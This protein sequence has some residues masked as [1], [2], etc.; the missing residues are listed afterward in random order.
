MF[1]H[2]IGE[3]LTNLDPTPP[4]DG[5]E[6]ILESGKYADYIESRLNYH[7]DNAFNPAAE[8]T[9]CL[10]PFNDSR[11]IAYRRAIEKVMDSLSLGALIY[12]SW[13]HPP[14]RIG[15]WDGYRGDNSQVIAP[16]TGQPAFT[17]PMG[18]TYGNLPAGL[19]FLGRMFDEPTL[20]RYV[21]A[22]E[23]G[24]RHRR[25]PVLPETQQ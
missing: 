22:Y 10:D 5:L 23:Q 13:N 4:I 16:H 19:Q 11:R 21:Y 7:L 15:D 12:P 17:V 8:P 25:P 14:A 18:Y 2:D 3:F 6:A 24:T 9:R 20:I 1:R